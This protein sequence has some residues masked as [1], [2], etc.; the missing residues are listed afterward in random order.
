MNLSITVRR[1]T[2]KPG[3][4]CNQILLPLK[5]P[6]KLDAIAP[7]M[8]TPLAILTQPNH[9]PPPQA[10]LPEGG[11]RVPAVQWQCGVVR[12][13][14]QHNRGSEAREGERESGLL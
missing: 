12:R 8:P 4:L 2:Y 13:P 9:T 1:L 5:I 6:L 14:V 3:I 10:A 11:V 7:T